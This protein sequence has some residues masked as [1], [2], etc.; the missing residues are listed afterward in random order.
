MGSVLVTDLGD[1]IAT[2]LGS[3]DR[4]RD[5]RVDGELEVEMLC[6]GR[7]NVVL[8]ISPQPDFIGSGDILAVAH[9]ILHEFQDVDLIV[10]RGERACLGIQNLT[11][12]SE[13]QL[14]IR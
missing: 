6:K 3:L 2:R 9:R 4:Q 12:P 8:D 10:P 13:I 14:E 11:R 7:R 1:H 5:Q